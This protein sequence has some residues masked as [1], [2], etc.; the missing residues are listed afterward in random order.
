MRPFTSFAASRPAVTSGASRTLRILNRGLL[1]A[2]SIAIAVSLAL[3]GVFIFNPKMAEEFTSG[4]R[5]SLFFAEL[6][7]DQIDPDLEHQYEQIIGVGHNSGDSVT[8]TLSALV[9]G[10]DAIELDVVSLD[11][12]LYSSHASPL[13]LV[14]GGLFRGP[15]VEEIWAAAAQTDLV[16]FDLKE[17]SPQFLRL[18]HDFLATHRRQ[19]QVIIVTR[20]PA[21]LR[22][23]AGS[24]PEVIR[25]YSIGDQSQLTTLREN[26]ELVR[27]I[28]GVSIR[29]TLLDEETTAW[30]TGQGLHVGA[31][32]VN[33]LERANELIRMGVEGITTDNLALLALFGG[34]Q[35]GEDPSQ[36][37]PVAPTPADE[38]RPGGGRPHEGTKR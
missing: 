24:M 10:A 26:P 29:H 23:F 35:R 1:G 18:V 36:Q 16:K 32:T 37:N 34:Q 5:P 20:D 11:G 19:H 25:Y 8:A 3:L 30:L 15:S 12:R 28:D 31:W 33:D 38:R 14:G 17:T 27:L 7:P 22:F 9:A 13:P 2:A 21:S 4:L 6:P